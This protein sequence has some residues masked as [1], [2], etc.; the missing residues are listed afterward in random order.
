[1]NVTKTNKSEIKVCDFIWVSQTVGGGTMEG[2]LRVLFES[3][4]TDSGK[5]AHICDGR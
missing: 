3:H 4:F 1:M 5:N 2:R